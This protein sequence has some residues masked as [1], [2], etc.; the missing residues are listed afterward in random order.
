LG[1]TRFC[2]GET[3]VFTG[4]F[5][6]SIFSGLG[7][8][9]LISIF[10]IVSGSDFSTVRLTKPIGLGTYNVTAV[11]SR[12]CSTIAM[13]Q[14]CHSGTGRDATR[15]APVKCVRGYILVST[16]AIGRIIDVFA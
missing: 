12:T 15:L 7:M 5:T 1:V 4:G 3:A 14:F 2:T 10:Q 16:A 6:A 9:R 8:G 11:S 13:N